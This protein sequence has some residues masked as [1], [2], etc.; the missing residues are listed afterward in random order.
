MAG[1]V[2]AAGSKVLAERA[3][4]EV[5]S[6]VAAARRGG[7]VFLGRTNMTELAY[8]GLGLNPHFERRPA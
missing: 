8:S 6:P 1:E 5:D 3:P 2:S 7:A 4:A